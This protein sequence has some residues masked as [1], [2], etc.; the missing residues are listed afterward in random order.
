MYAIV[1]IRGQQFRVEESQII[2][3]PHIQE[4]I[5]KAIT[6]DKILLLGDE[7]NTKVGQPLVKGAKVTGKI[8][9]HGREKK[10]VVWKKKRRKGYQV[11]NGHRQQF[12]R[13]QIEKIS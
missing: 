8:V 11:K 4:E 7:E 2:K 12:T 10:V 3:V 1:D 13:I 5:G 6:F 9:D